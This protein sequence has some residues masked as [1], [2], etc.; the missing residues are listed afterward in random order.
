MGAWS[1]TVA[2]ST[3]AVAATAGTNG[4]KLSA[5][6][7]LCERASPYTNE[8]IQVFNLLLGIYR[9]LNAN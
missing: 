8:G 4:G 1:P 3:P 2:P 5:A 6:R 7:W 9:K